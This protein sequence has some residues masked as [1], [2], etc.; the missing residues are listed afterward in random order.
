MS[1]TDDVKNPQTPAFWYIPADDAD[2]DDTLMYPLADGSCPD[3]R[4]AAYPL[5]RHPA[6]D[7][8]TRSERDA[9]LE[10][11]WT[12][13]KTI[14]EQRGEI[15]RLNDLLGKANA[16][17]R[18]RQQ[19]IKDL[20]VAAQDDARDAAVAH[21]ARLAEKVAGKETADTIRSVVI[22]GDACPHCQRY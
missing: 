5:Y 18:I 17:C 16:L 2:S 4:P 3:Q 1:Q 19:R 15:A 7:D 22:R 14:E 20:E 10:M 13:A 8:A 9:L 21:T 6:Q 11:N 12:Q